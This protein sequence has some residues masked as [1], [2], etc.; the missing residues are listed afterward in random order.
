MSKPTDALPSVGTA[1]HLSLPSVGTAQHLSLPSV[2]TVEHTR[3]SYV[4]QMEREK[5]IAD[6][7]DQY[8]S[9]KYSFATDPV[10]LC[11]LWYYPKYMVSLNPAIRAVLNVPK[12]KALDREVERT[13]LINHHT[14]VTVLK[15]LKILVVQY[16][17][18]F[19][20]KLINSI[21]AYGRKPIGG[22]S[23]K[24]KQKRKTKTKRKV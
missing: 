22:K 23:R 8:I 7:K 6:L 10:R 12:Y 21:L 17:L 5:Y 24:I 20:E 13:V 3:E 1:Q 4:K 15:E 16:N 14:K 19:H 2:G 11:E 9:G 18:E